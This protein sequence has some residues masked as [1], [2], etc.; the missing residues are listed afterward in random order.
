[1]ELITPNV[2]GV[3]YDPAK[4]VRIVDPQQWKFY[5]CKGLKPYD[6]YP[7]RGIIVMVFDRAESYPYYKEYMDRYKESDVNE[8]L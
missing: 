5:M 3:P 6:V 7:S 1:M 4:G 8:K 2:K